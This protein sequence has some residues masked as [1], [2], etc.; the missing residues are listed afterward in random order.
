MEKN[1]GR[2]A[3][4]RTTKSQNNE[5]E[6]GNKY[7]KFGSQI[8]AGYYIARVI[9]VRGGARI[10]NLLFNKLVKHTS[11]NGLYA[12]LFR[13]LYSQIGETLV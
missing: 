1:E 6:E 10:L 3:R 2:R 7:F 8:Y 13:Y 4:R 12:E 5:N 11:P 9:N